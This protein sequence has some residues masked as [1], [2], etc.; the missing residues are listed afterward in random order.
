MDMINYTKVPNEILEDSQ[1]SIQARYLLIVLLKHCGQDESCFPS[2]KT[3][4]KTLSLSDRQIRNLLNELITNKFI[5]KRRFGF[6]KSNTYII[7][8]KYRKSTSGH[9][10]TLFPFHEGT[11]IPTNITYR[12]EKGKRGAKAGFR[13]LSK[14]M[15]KIG[16]RR[17]N[18]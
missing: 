9:L 8:K 16:L 4:A 3:L 18:K 10:R 7:Q 17:S 12:K 2:Q 13:H 15:E 11:T 1:L 5:E 6:N 14:Q